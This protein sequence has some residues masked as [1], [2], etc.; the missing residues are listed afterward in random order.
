[1]R[2][3]GCALLLLVA[4]LIVLSPSLLTTASDGAFAHQ[5]VR[6]NQLDPRQYR[7]AAE[8]QIWA[9]STCSTAA[10]TEVMNYYG[11]RYRISD[12]LAP[13]H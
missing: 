3:F 5:L 13:D 1:M 9:A 2:K 11:H 10:M 4:L 12:V 8:Y 6:L 7:S